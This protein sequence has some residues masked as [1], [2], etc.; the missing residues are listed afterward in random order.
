MLPSCD[1]HQGKHIQSVYKFTLTDKIV[2]NAITGGLEVPYDGYPMTFSTYH[3][4]AS[5]VERLVIAYYNTHGK[6][7][8]EGKYFAT[9]L[10]PYVDTTQPYERVDDVATN[11]Y[12]LR[13]NRETYS[14]LKVLDGCTVYTVYDVGRGWEG[15]GDKGNDVVLNVFVGY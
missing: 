3:R 6:F 1:Y 7:P 11:L 12:R 5:S 15:D 9:D 2:S 14:E 10:R 4:T 8:R 13:F